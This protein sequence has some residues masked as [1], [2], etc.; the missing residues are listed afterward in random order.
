[1]EFPKERNTDPVVGNDNTATSTDPSGNVGVIPSPE[2]Y[3][4]ERVGPLQGIPK[5]L[6]SIVVSE[7]S[8]GDEPASAVIIE[9]RSVADRVL[10]LDAT[11]GVTINVYI[12]FVLQRNSK[13]VFS[14]NWGLTRSEH[15]YPD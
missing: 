3:L 9:T 5:N 6:Q 15:K 8:V 7:K 4:D 14:E 10:Q 2:P 12:A 11:A 13:D 1:M